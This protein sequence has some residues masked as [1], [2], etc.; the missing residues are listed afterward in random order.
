[1]VNFLSIFLM[2]LFSFCSIP[3]FAKGVIPWQEEELRFVKVYQVLGIDPIGPGMYAIL[4]NHV[5]KNLSIVWLVEEQCNIPIRWH[6]L[7]HE[8]AIEFFPWLL[9]QF[10]LNKE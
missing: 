6:E 7:T 10:Y 3:L 1:M 2:S 9:K 4:C 5:Q 8:E